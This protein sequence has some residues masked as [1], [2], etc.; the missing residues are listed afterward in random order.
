MPRREGAALVLARLYETAPSARVGARL[1]KAWILV[2]E[3]GEGELAKGRCGAAGQRMVATRL[4]ERSVE[5]ESQQ[6]MAAEMAGI[7]VQRL[8]V[9]SSEAL[10]NLRGAH[11][12]DGGKQAAR[13][14]RTLEREASKQLRDQGVEGF[15]ELQGSRRLQRRGG[16]FGAGATGSFALERERE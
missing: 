10:M 3:N 1:S 11:G 2:Q 5:G 16:A 12:V 15:A 14:E 7:L 6:R 9:P 4:S 8:A 13:D